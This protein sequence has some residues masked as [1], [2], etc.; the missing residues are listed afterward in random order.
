MLKVRTVKFIFTRGD[1]TMIPWQ[2]GISMEPDTKGSST[3]ISD[4]HFNDN[5]AVDEIFGEGPTTDDNLH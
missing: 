4:V 2:S 1:E 5:Q 3:P